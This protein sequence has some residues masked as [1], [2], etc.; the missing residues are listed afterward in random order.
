MLNLS[1]LWLL[2]LHG[3]SQSKEFVDKCD[4]SGV[5]WSRIKRSPEHR[6]SKWWTLGNY[7]TLNDITAYY[8]RTKSKE[9]TRKFVYL[10]IIQST[11]H[12]CRGSKPESDVSSVGEK[13]TNQRGSMQNRG[14]RCQHCSRCTMAH[15]MC[16]GWHGFARVGDNGVKPPF[17]NG[18]QIEN[19]EERQSIKPASC[20]E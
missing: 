10:V 5:K 1:T 7:K 9:W 20:L 19:Y 15:G 8:W 13:A 4:L 16:D 2:V 11:L 17:L 3:S 14:V 12:A 18:Y 6:L